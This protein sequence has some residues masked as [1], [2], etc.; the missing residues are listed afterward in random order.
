MGTSSDLP[1]APCRVGSQG[2]HT[3]AWLLLTP[4]GPDLSPSLSA[5]PALLRAV[6]PVSATP[7]LISGLPSH[8]LCLVS[9][10]SLGGPERAWGALLTFHV[11]ILEVK[12]I[13]QNEPGF[14]VVS[15][16]LL[17]VAGAWQDVLGDGQ[18]QTVIQTP[19]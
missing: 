10:P 9:I 11:A 15:R 8:T 4:P 17:H 7:V 14:P 1:L 3:A 19:S 13:A 12:R 16:R 5:L 6:P 2:P 18:V